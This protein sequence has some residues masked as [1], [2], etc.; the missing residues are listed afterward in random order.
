[1]N[2]SSSLPE[3]S[4]TSTPSYLVISLAL[5]QREHQRLDVSARRL[6][7]RAIPV[8]Q[9]YELRQQWQTT[10]GFLAHLPPLLASL[11]RLIEQYEHGNVAE[12]AY[13]DVLYQIA[14]YRN[15]GWKCLEQQYG[16]LGHY[17]DTK[18][19]LR[20]SYLQLFTSTFEASA[21]LTCQE[22]AELLQGLHPQWCAGLRSEMCREVFERNQKILS[23]T[24]ARYMLRSM[25]GSMG[26][27]VHDSN[28]MNQAVSASRHQPTQ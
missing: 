11:D 12:A 24:L 14:V 16:H 26:V 8:E 17:L 25:A 22:A 15:A 3:D 18:G 13:G 1:M 10:L 28:G 6:R 4:M 21:P 19:I 20:A 7:S 2:A 27:T 5:M 23:G 9:L